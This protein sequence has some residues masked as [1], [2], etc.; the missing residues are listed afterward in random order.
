MKRLSLGVAL[1]SLTFMLNSCKE[2][3]K[4]SELVLDMSK[5]ATIVVY[6]YAELDQS[7]DGI[8]KVPDGTQIMLRI[9][10]DNF[11]GSAKSYWTE[12]FS[13]ENGKIEAEVPVTNK[14][15][16]VEIF[17]YEFYYDQKQPYGSVNNTVPKY[18]KYVGGIISETGVKTGEV[19]TH[20]VSYSV[21]GFDDFTEVVKRNFKLIADFDATTATND[22]APNGTKVT[23]YAAGWFVEK[24]VAGNDGHLDN[25]ELPN[26]KQISIRFEASK[27]LSDTERK[28]YLYERINIASYTGISPV[29]VEVNMGTG[30]L[31]Q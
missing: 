26:N 8:E 23:F 1:L 2:D 21:N 17:P 9:T 5:T 18:Y 25:V 28:N 13:V 20:E 15:V 27:K 6:A 10:Y 31:W 22:P 16:T 7:K 4:T 19:R 12:L 29:R 24:T 3:V 14:G 30:Q 11:N